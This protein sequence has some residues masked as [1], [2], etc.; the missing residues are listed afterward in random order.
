[1]K[2]EVDSYADYWCEFYKNHPDPTEFRSMVARD[3]VLTKIFNFASVPSIWPVENGDF[4]SYPFDQKI[5]ELTGISDEDGA[6]LRDKR[7]RE[8]NEWLD[9]LANLF[10]L[11]S[12]TVRLKECL[13]KWDE[14]K[15]G[16]ISQEEKIER[17]ERAFCEHLAMN[18]TVTYKEIDQ[19]RVSETFYG[20]YYPHFLVTWVH[21]HDL[22]KQKKITQCH[23]NY[24]FHEPDEKELRK[25]FDEWE[26]HS[27]GSL[28]RFRKV[29]G[30]EDIVWRPDQPKEYQIFLKYRKEPLALPFTQ[31]GH[32]IYPIA[33]R[34]GGLMTKK[35]NTLAFYLHSLSDLRFVFHS[36]KAKE[37]ESTQE[38]ETK[39]FELLL[40]YK[41]SEHVSLA[42][43]LETRLNKFPID[44]YRKA[45]A[46]KRDPKRE[47][48]KF[49]DKQLENP[50][51]PNSLTVQSKW[52][53]SLN[54][55]P[56]HET[57]FN[58]T[59]EDHGE[60]DAVTSIPKNPCD[61]LEQKQDNIR[62]QKSYQRLRDDLSPETRRF[63]KIWKEHPEASEKDLADL[64]GISKAMVK[65]HKVYIRKKAAKLK[66]IPN[67]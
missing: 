66:N 59:G 6:Y 17:L 21:I 14:S 51:S 62:C 63:I 49:I 56:G 27:V 61:L 3:P 18:R 57:D 40:R 36:P 9:Y 44:Y 43:Y 15:G 37:D 11:V 12:A 29:Q 23:I 38:I 2:L 1:M 58:P 60:F 39:L 46:K 67:P 4:K 45:S 32:F 54:I 5:A 16:K 24:L 35:A 64:M 52:P 8:P 25:E 31:E 41:P 7:I 53:G 22:K 19:C 26:E 42:G 33:K 48:D 10:Q 55:E 13:D 34:Y 50:D 30:M 20:G 65:K 28:V 47:R